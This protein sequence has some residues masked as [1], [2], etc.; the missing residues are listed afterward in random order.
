MGL[1]MTTKLGQTCGLLN[2]YKHRKKAVM[3]IKLQ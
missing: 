2:C 3:A 1:M